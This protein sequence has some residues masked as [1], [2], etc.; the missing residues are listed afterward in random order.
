MKLTL[1]HEEEDEKRW[2][3]ETASSVRFPTTP[4]TS[5]TPTVDVPSPPSFPDPKPSGHIAKRAK[6]RRSQRPA[7]PNPSL[8]KI[9]APE[10]EKTGKFMRDPELL[11]LSLFKD[12]PKGMTYPEIAEKIV[13]YGNELLQ[14]GYDNDLDVDDAGIAVQNLLDQNLIMPL[15]S[16]PPIKYGLNPNKNEP[17]KQDLSKFKHLVRYGKLA[18][19]VDPNYIDPNDDAIL[20]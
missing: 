6:S 7:V 19:Y 20:T 5:L 10:F 13:A 17:E 8:Q 1:L 18:Q 11:V 2:R 16:D 15:G 4:K 14:R 3:A 9:A 12:N